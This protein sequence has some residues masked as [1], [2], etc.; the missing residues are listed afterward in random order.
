MPH[1]K[2]DTLLAAAAE[3][4]ASDLHLRS[5]APAHV[6]VDGTLR[7]LDDSV[8]PTGEIEAMTVA[9]MPS[10]NR[11]ELREMRDTD[12]AYQTESGLRFRVNVFDELHGRGAVFRRVN[13]SIAS[14]D[15]L[16]LSAAVQGL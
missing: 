10:R 15:E 13:T 16:G 14:A 11:D 5:G 6:R 1:Q 9:V 2:L 3:L 8:L 7:P 12:F 4:G